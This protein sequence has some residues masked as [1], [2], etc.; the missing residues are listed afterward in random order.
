MHTFKWTIRAVLSIGLLQ[1]V[2]CTKNIDTVTN[3]SVTVETS[4]NLTFP[5]TNEFANCKLRYIIHE[6]DIN[7]VLVTGLFTY[8]AAGNPYSL[9]YEDRAGWGSQRNHYFYYDKLN[10]LREYRNGYG[11]ND[12]VE[13]VWHRYGYNSNNQIIV[14]STIVPGWVYEIDGQTYVHPESIWKISKFTYDA[15]GRIIKEEIKDVS[16]GTTR[17]PTYTYDSRGNIGVIGWRSS[18]YD[19]KVSLFRSHPVF[20]FLHRNYSRNNPAPQPKYNSRGLPLS[21]RPSNDAFFN[22]VPSNN[23]EGFIGGIERIVYDCK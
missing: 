1:A 5:Y 3:D 23:N 19:Y 21:F 20:Q 15:Q 18:S 17:Y 4:S 8:N 12:P 14:D 10:R 7:G 22:S 11:P 6:D 16:S 13:A 2:S 9:T